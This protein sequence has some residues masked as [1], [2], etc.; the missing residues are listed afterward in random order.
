M[1]EMQQ[2]RLGLRHFLSTAV[3]LWA[4]MGRPWAGDEGD[5]RGYWNDLE[6]YAARQLSEAAYLPQQASEIWGIPAEV[7]QEYAVIRQSVWEF[8]SEADEKR[9]HAA[10]GD[11]LELL[12]PPGA[13]GLLTYWGHHRSDSLSRPL[14][15]PADNLFDGNSSLIF[16]KGSYLVRLRATS[17]PEQAEEQLSGLAARLA[18]A[19]QEEDV[20]P[21]TVINLP[22]KDLLPGSMTV[23]LGPEG[24]RRNAEF[25]SRLL[26]LLRFAHG[27]EVT[28]ARYSTGEQ[29][30]LTGY[31]TPAL[32]AEAQQRLQSSGELSGMQ[33]KKSGILLALAIPSEQATDLLAEVNYNPKVQ[34]I[35]D[36]VRT[37]QSEA[38]NL[39]ELFTSWVMFCLFYVVCITVFGTA[40]GLARYALH[41][42]YP[43]FAA[44][45][46][47]VRLNLTGT[48]T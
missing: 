31:P 41:R 2:R 15:L 18:D 46:D 48:G 36:K 4:C 43:A 32:A 38:L 45:N 27:V 44:R 22:K 25:P 33:L 23:Y 17:R 6:G 5:L 47:M 16:C 42:R 21:V 39:Y 30:F 19:V 40:A 20:P 24:L 7:L 10:Q 3:L 37:L 13:F 29:L 35:K 26:P 28:A 34:W 9:G 1:K 14:S 11:V 12:D 8:R